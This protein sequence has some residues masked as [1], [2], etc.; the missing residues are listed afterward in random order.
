MIL[1]QPKLYTLLTKVAPNYNSDAFVY[2]LLLEHKDNI[3]TEELG[4]GK[5]YIPS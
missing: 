5:F 3:T 2:L 1:L 4:N